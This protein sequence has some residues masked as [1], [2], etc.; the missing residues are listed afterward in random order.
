MQSLKGMRIG[1]SEGNSSDTILNFAL[2]SV[3]L[4]RSDCEIRNLTPEEII[5][6]MVNG[7][8]DACALWSPF[9]F[10]LQKKMDNDAVLLANNLNFSNRLASLSS[11]ITSES[12]AASNKEVLLGFTR[13][14]Y[15]GMDYR[16]MED[17][18]RQVAGWVAETIGGNTDNLY[19][20]RRDADWSTKGYVALGV[21]DGT[22]GRLYEAQQ[23][24]F[25][26]NGAVAKQVPI[27]E[28]VLLDIMTKA[29]E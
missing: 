13:A 22:V 28:Y 8:L 6:E 1:T 11:W 9:T 10:E 18:M 16:A 2:E 26:K 23:K 17:N 20:Q 12:F 27:S 15:R 24:N 21:A 7:R 25:L 3:G 14:V 5:Q 29:V 19:E 4:S